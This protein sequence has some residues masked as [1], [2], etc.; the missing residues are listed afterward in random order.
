[1]IIAEARR[2]HATTGLSITDQ[3]SPLA[4]TVGCRSRSE[5]EVRL[6]N[7]IGRRA[8]LISKVPAAAVPA[9]GVLRQ[10]P[11]HSVGASTR[12]YSSWTTWLSDGAADITIT[13]C[14]Q[15]IDLV[16]SYK[17]SEARL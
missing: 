17:R 3:R 16:Q 10:V 13:T 14:E 12:I 5:V 2:T 8:A 7:M 6:E 11:C 15:Y 4:V 1:M 9:F